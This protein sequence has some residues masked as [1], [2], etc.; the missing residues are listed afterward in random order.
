MQSPRPSDDGLPE[1][2]TGY[3]EPGGKRV[4]LAILTK[5][6]EEYNFQPPERPLSSRDQAF[7][8]VELEV[9]ARYVFQAVTLWTIGMYSEGSTVNLETPRGVIEFL[10][11]VLLEHWTPERVAEIFVSISDS[12]LIEI[13]DPYSLKPLQIL[14]PEQD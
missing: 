9:T 4:K 13:I 7:L 10:T 8:N 2:T 5:W 3:V 1:F 6:K 14:A 11:P 12:D